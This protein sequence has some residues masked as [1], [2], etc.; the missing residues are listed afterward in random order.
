MVYTGSKTV[1]T[2]TAGTVA[3]VIGGITDDDDF[4]RAG[5]ELYDEC[6]DAAGKFGKEVVGTVNGVLDGTPVV[7]HVKGAIHDVC[8]DDEGA[9]K[10]YFSANRSTGVLAGGVGGA[11]LGGPV[12]AVIL[13]AEG[14]VDCLKLKAK[15]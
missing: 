15:L 10:A 6:G 12:G 3:H 13:A 9:R 8:G 11:L 5:E 2:A 7:G 4:K 1:V 14:N